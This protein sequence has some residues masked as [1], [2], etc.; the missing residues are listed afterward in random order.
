MHTMVTGKDD[1]VIR[2]HA[3]IPEGQVMLD[4]I[5]RALDSMVHIAA[6]AHLAPSPTPVVEVQVPSQVL[7]LRAIF[8]SSAEQKNVPGCQPPGPLVA[9]D[10]GDQTQ[11]QTAGTCSHG[12]QQAFS[13]GGRSTSTIL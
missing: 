12:C 9:Q 11:S 8:P 4:E 1:D 6:D 5:D 2:P 7:G 13:E 10:L 3:G